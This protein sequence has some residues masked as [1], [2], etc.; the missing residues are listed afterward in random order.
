VGLLVLWVAKDY[1]GYLILRGSL[2]PS[3]VGADGLIGARGVVRSA[4]EPHG[5][6]QIGGELWRARAVTPGE[7]VEAGRPVEVRAVH[8]LTLLVAPGPGDPP[9]AEP[10]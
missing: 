8:G 7:R 2:G 1:V 3:R 6:V 4:L 10:S 9:G 5:Q